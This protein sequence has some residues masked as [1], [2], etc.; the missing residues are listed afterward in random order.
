MSTTNQSKIVPKKVLVTGAS[1]LLGVAAIEKF[2]AAGWKVVGLSGRKPQ[3]PSGRDI[4]FLSVDLR[5]EGRARAAFEPLT[6]ITH[7]AYTALHEKPELV[8]G[9]SSKDQIETNNAMLRNVV[10]PVVRTASNFMSAFCRER[11]STACT[12]TRSLSRLANVMP[13]RTTR[14]SSSTRKPMWVRWAPSKASITRLFVR[15]SSLVQPRA[16]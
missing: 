8:A 3:V 13:P 16:R 9:W 1:G 5:D 2:L 10:E 14:T 12:C 4:D 11:R 7:I 15:N 6:D